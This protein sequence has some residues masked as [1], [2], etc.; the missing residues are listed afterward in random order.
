MIL[1]SLSNLLVILSCTKYVILH[2]SMLSKP[3]YNYEI[4]NNDVVAADGRHDDC[5]VKRDE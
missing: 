2:N 1:V 5:K 3:Q 4:E